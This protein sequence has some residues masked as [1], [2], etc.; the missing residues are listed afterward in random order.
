M[1]IRDRLDGENQDNIYLYG[2]AGFGVGETPFSFSAHLGYS[3]GNAGAGP[4]GWV[5]SPTGTHLDWSIGVSYDL[6]GPLE[7]SVTYIDTDIGR[8]EAAEFQL[9]NSGYRFGIG[10]ATAVFAISASF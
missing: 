6:P 2:D 4:N 8:E 3:D 9:I 7:A 10:R 1:C 5:A